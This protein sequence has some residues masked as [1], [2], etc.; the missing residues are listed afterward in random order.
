MPL[1]ILLDQNAPLG[2]RRPLSHHDVLVARQ[3]GWETLINGDLPRAAEEAGFDILI[4][5]DRNIPHQQ[6]LTGRQI[7]LIELTTGAWHVV[8][9]HLNRVVDAVDAAKP[10]SYTAVAIPRPS[11]RRKLFSGGLGLSPLPR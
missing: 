3:M 4:T 5:C 2:L 11:L 6:N 10:G 1:R 9:L 8:R 7:A